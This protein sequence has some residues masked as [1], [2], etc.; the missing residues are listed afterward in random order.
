[1]KANVII[2]IETATEIK[3]VP[4]T[5]TEENVERVYKFHEAINRGHIIYAYEAE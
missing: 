4:V 2:V 5:V 1:M 3:R